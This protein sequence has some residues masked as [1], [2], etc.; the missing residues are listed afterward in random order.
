MPLPVEP[1]YVEQLAEAMIGEG[2]VMEGDEL[3]ENQACPDARGGRDLRAW[4]ALARLIAD[5]RPA[6]RNDM[7][8]IVTALALITA[9]A[10]CGPDRRAAYQSQLEAD[11]QA[12]LNGTTPN[13]CIAYKLDVQKCS[14][15]TGNPIAAGCY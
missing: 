3:S 9:L 14:V 6:R 2:L 11:H 15:I 8:K 7:I 10:G 12:C 13:A 4:D 1:R 5:S